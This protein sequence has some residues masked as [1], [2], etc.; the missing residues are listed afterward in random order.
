[1]DNPNFSL[2]PFESQ[3]GGRPNKDMKMGSAPSFGAP[4][5]HI[6]D[7]VAQGLKKLNFTAKLAQ[8][9]E[10]EEELRMHLLTLR[11]QTDRNTPTG[12]KIDF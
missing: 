9:V 8:H 1:M 2:S 6:F 5:G 3:L 11:C 10:V 7:V 12:F 4:G